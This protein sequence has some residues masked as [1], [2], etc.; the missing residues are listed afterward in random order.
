VFIAVLEK[1]SVLS[2]LLRSPSTKQ[3]FARVEFG[4]EFTTNN[5]VAQKSHMM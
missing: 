5:K 4:V 1:D 3:L 2:H